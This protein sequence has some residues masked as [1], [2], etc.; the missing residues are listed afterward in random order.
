M[1]QIIKHRMQTAIKTNV[2]IEVEIGEGNN[3]L[4]AH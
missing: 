1:K 2:P 3:W 4:A